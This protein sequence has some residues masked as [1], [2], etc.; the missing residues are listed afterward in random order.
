LG[1]GLALNPSHGDVAADILEATGGV[2]ADAIIEASGS[3]VALEGAFRFLRK[4]GRCA[5]IGLPSAPVRLN[6]GPDVIFKEA[7]IIGIHGR[8]MFRTW[9][10]MQELLASGLLNVEAVATHEMPLS[11][12][13]EALALLEAGTGGKV[14][15]YPGC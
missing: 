11:K 12:A 1:C 5:L 6:L 8:E 14:I 9:T 7:T 4:G 10:R 13:G 2:G 3:V 15:L